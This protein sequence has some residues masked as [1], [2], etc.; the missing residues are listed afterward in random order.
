MF[1]WLYSESCKVS[2]RFL[3]ENHVLLVLHITT[4]VVATSCHFLS[5]EQ[6]CM[7]YIL[8]IAKLL[9][10]LSDGLRACEDLYEIKRKILSFVN[11]NIWISQ[12]CIIIYIV[13]YILFYSILYFINVLFGRHVNLLFLL[14]FVFSLYFIILNAKTLAL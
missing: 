3:Y 2:I 14:Q 12:A 7:V 5:R 13:N 6:Q 1:S 10:S 9:N 4:Y 8:L 11:F